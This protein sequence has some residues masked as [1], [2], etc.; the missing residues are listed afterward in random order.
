MNDL[1]R[2]NRRQW[3]GTTGGALSLAALGGTHRVSGA[4]AKRPRIAAVVT[5]FTFRSHAHVILENFLE[6]Y[7]FNGQLTDPGMDVVGLYVDQ[8][9]SGD[10]SRGVA[11]QYGI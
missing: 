7:Y 2:L 5:E 10:M 6:P 4:D 8:F 9:P 1:N 3:I 11:K